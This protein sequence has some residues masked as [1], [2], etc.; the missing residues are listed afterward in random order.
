MRKH[1]HNNLG[2]PGVKKSKPVGHMSRV[3][4]IGAGFVLTLASALVFLYFAGHAF[5]HGCRTSGWSEVQ[6]HVTEMSLVESS[7]SVSRLHSITLK[8]RY[9]LRYVYEVDGELY[10]GKRLAFGRSKEIPHTKVY[11]FMNR[12]GEGYLVTVYYDPANPNNAVLERGIGFW[13]YGV[14]VCG[15][16]LLGACVVVP[17]QFNRKAKQ[18]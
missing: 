7:V 3:L 16:L 2:A 10:E 1:R 11:G 12:Y 17:I 15:L 14:A 4:I 6:G 9:A 5:Y 18:K 8:Y 13:S